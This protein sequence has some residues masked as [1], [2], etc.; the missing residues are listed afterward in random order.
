M[1]SKCPW[2]WSSATVVAPAAAIARAMR[3]ASSPGSMTTASFV[4][5]STRIEQLHWRG[6]T[7]IVSMRARIIGGLPK[8]RGDVDRL[9]DWTT[10]GLGESGKRALS[11][12]PALPVASWSKSR[13]HR[14]DDV[15]VV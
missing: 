3:S 8:E 5:S 10:G 13:V 4:A 15:H 1:W 7:G 12:S 9:G 6:P 2:V 14:D 11:Q